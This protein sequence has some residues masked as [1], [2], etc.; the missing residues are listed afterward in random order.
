[1][2]MI[3]VSVRWYNIGVH[4]GLPINTLDSFRSKNRNDSDKCL[5]CVI[6]EWIKNFPKKQGL[7]TW[8]KVAIAV[9]S[10]VGGDNPSEACKIAKEYA[11]KLYLLIMMIKIS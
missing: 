3:N 9:S 11:S 5:T 10:R 2:A 1:M 8:R 4:F 7:P 6:A